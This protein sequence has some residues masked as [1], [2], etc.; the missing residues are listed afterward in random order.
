MIE[1]LTTNH[2]DKIFD[3]FDSAAKEIR[4]ISPFLTRAMTEKLA[5]IVKT[6]GISCTFITR[7]YVNDLL[8][9]ANSTEALR[10][11]LDAGIEVYAVKGLHTKLYLFDD[12]SAVLGSANFTM[13][14]FKSNIELSVLISQEQKLLTELDDY[15]KTLLSRIKAAEGGVVDRAMLDSAQSI[16]LRDWDSKKDASLRVKSAK[17]FGATLDKKLDDP[18]QALKELDACESDLDIIFD[19]FRSTEKRDAVLLDHTVWLKFDGEGNNRIAPEEAF[20][21]IDVSVDGKRVYIQNYPFRVGSIK[22]GDELY[23]AAISTDSKGRNQPIIMG[24]GLFRA[25]S[26]NNYV[27]DA[28][29]EKNDWMD[30]YP[31]YCVMDTCEV[32]DTPVRNGIPMDRVWEA[33]GSDTY[34]ASFG[35]TEDDMAA[36]R[37]HYQKAH[38]RLSGNAKLFIDKEFETLKKKYGV[39]TYVSE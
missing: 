26:D 38:I 27:D 17:M 7:L 10:G 13:S 2:S 35:R 24:R 22:A 37:K 4:I 25:F 1:L 6:Q 16:Y 23:L 8:A 28:M 32:L 18:H 14:G 30:R 11:M 19:A 9:K 31:W 3:Q 21:I 12:T 36:T 34:Y 29:L 5:H 20:P 39:K 33:L 15:F